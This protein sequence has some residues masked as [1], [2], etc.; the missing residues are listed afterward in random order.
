MVTDPFTPGTAGPASGGPLAR[1]SQGPARFWLRQTDTMDTLKAFFLGLVTTAVFYEI[2]PIPFLEPGRLL[3]VFDN[4]A[5]ALIVGMAWWCLYLL[6]FKLLN[7]RW[8]AR[9]HHAIEH[10]AGE[11][12]LER[13]LEESDTAAA[14]DGIAAQ[15]QRM[16]LKRVES[17]LMFQRVA[18]GLRSAPTFRDKEGL[19]SL[20]ESEAEIEIRRLEAAYTILQVFIWAIP[21]L[22]FIGTVHGIGSAVSEFSQFIRTAEGG[23]G[24]SSQMRT[25]LA[26]VTGGLSLAFNTTFLALVLVIPVML[27]TSLM[28][29]AQEELLL[30]IESFILERLLPRLKLESAAIQTV[31][32]YEEQLQRVLELSSRWSLQVEPLIGQFTRQAEMLGHQVAGIQPLVKE[33]TDRV[34]GASAG[35]T[36]ES[37]PGRI[38]TREGD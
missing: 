18:A 35:M 20:L 25:A 30:A 2:Y 27:L 26:G 38:S 4:W 3:G 22:G 10:G 29:K 37:P 33:F 12:A 17:S 19:I 21:I 28:Q 6:L 36:A 16:K 8:Q 15:L 14:V 7:H 9:I 13:A 11:A 31:Q 34:L 1:P 23:G 5:S 24:L 32:D